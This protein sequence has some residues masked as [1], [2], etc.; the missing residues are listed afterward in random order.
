M[1]LIKVSRDT[2]KVAHSKFCI[3]DVVSTVVLQQMNEMNLKE[4]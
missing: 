4:M 1:L 3:T 2:L